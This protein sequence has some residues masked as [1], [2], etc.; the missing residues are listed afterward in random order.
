MA[1]S[2]ITIGGEGSIPI[3]DLRRVSGRTWKIVYEKSYRSG[4]IPEGY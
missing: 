2:T 4:Y 1:D 3:S